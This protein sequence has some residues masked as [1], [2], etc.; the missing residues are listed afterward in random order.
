MVAMVAVAVAVACFRVYP[1]LAR[2]AGHVLRHSNE[3][4]CHYQS[5]TGHMLCSFPNVGTHAACYV[6]MGPYSV[7]A[8]WRR[9]LYRAWYYCPAFPTF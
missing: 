1:H 9:Y 3:P 4:H 7:A 6:E 2:V 8:V 5:D